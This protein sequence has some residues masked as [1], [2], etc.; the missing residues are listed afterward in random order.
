MTTEEQLAHLMPYIQQIARYYAR[1]L[2]HGETDDLVQAA[3][4]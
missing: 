4:V 3:S 2:R 1:L